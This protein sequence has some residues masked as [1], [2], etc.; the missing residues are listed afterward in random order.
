M[1]RSEQIISAAITCFA[2]QGFGPSK[3]ADVAAAAGVGKGTVYEYFRSKE[4]LLLA[5]CIAACEQNETRITERL[6]KAH[7]EH[8]VAL[9][10]HQ[11]RCVL[12]VLLRPQQP[13]QRLFADLVQACSQQPELAAQAKEKLSQKLSQWMALDAGPTTTWF[14]PTIVPRCGN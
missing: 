7:C 3:I 11:I 1:D 2:E 10:Y 12:E 6:S 4:H 14:R 5:A 8:P 13:E 9:M